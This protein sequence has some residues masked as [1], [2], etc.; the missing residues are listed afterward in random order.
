MNMEE[1]QKS[2]E[3]LLSRFL[4]LEKLKAAFVAAEFVY[5]V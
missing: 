5:S 1:F 2:P 3:N 4:I